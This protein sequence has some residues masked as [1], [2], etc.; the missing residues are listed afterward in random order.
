MSGLSLRFVGDDNDKIRKFHI[1]IVLDEN[2]IFFG[3]QQN[4][5]QSTDLG[6]HNLKMG[7]L[8]KIGSMVME[9]WALEVGEISKKSEIS[10][11]FSQ[12]SNGK[13]WFCVQ[14]NV[15]NHGKT[16]KKEDFLYFIK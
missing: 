14:K 11:K 5:T 15:E 12:N 16:Q 1:F 8:F 13:S 4:I 9:I 2:F 7:L 6:E 3:Q 10:S